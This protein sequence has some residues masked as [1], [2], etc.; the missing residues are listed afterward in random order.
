[1]T[2]A[3]EKILANHEIWEAFVN[4]QNAHMNDFASIDELL[5]DSLSLQ[6]MESYQVSKNS[7]REIITRLRSKK[8]RHVA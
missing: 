3:I 6:I 1:M 2:E 7:L 5:D 4:N 8:K